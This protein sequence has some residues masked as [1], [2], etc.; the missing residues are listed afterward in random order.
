MVH[1]NSA[2]P[3]SLARGTPHIA[4]SPVIQERVSLDSPRRQ[5]PTSLA[6]D[7]FTQESGLQNRRH[8]RSGS[9]PQEASSALRQRPTS[10]SSLSSPRSSPIV[11]A[12]SPQPSSKSVVIPKLHISSRHSSPAPPEPVVARTQPLHPSTLTSL[13]ESSNVEAGPILRREN[14]QQSEVSKTSQNSVLTSGNQSLVKGLEKPRVPP[15]PSLGNTSNLEPRV[16]GRPGKISPFSTPPSSDEST[17]SEKSAIKIGAARFHHPTLGNKTSYLPTRSTIP[18]EKDSST[19]REDKQENRV[20]KPDAGGVVQQPQ[21]SHDQLH[22]RPGLPPRRQ[23]NP[24]IHEILVATPAPKPTL[25]RSWTDQR[26]RQRIATSKAHTRVSSMELDTAHPIIKTSVKLPPPRSQT[27]I[28]SNTQ[29]LGSAVRSQPNHQVEVLA[30]KNSLNEREIN[31][32]ALND[33]RNSFDYPDISRVN[34]RPPYTLQGVRTIETGYDTKLFDIS[35]QYV[36]TT[37]YLTKAWDLRSG[38]TVMNLIHGEREVKIT[39]IAFK[40]GTTVDD[41]GLRLWLGTNYGDLHEADI[42]T[43]KIILTKSAA[44]NRREIVKIFRYQNAMWT[45]DDDGRLYIWPPDNSGLPSL[46]SN[47]ISKKL[48]RGHSF[49]ITVQH[50]LW[51]ANGKDIRVFFPN[52]EAIEFSFGE[53]P[54]HQPGAGEVT[55]GAVIPSQ[56]NRVYFGHA[57]GK[58]TCYSAV[59][60]SL[61]GIFNVSAYKINALAG[62]G[63][64]LWAGYSTG[65]I[66]VYD[67]ATQP[68]TLKKDWLAHQHPIVNI[69]VD[70]SSLWR[71]GTLRVAS[72]GTDNAVRLWDGTLEHDWLGMT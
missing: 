44:H 16:V 25:Q 70:R 12:E 55:S 13:H 31:H 8:R 33:T 17:E 7:Y 66:Y 39:A 6:Q 21:L 11:R 32:S 5:P 9:S 67:T 15:K 30:S 2:L 43:Q 48:P 62:A 69:L 45:L 41:E 53:K 37:G 19:S 22:S 47:P 20:L 35:Y 26:D 42:P 51:L 40:S 60:F 57:D 28:Y 14:P 36:C 65:M 54:L 64:Y 58:I 18:H 61:L 4:A 59:D 34:R 3:T 49:S 27:Y 1:S 68:W 29:G 72:I 24:K 10:I 52:S 63:S 38:E 46:H 56:L 71:S 50:T 23:V